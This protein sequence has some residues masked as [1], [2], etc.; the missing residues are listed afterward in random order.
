MTNTDLIILGVD[1]H[2]MSEAWFYVPRMLN[3]DTL[4]FHQIPGDEGWNTK[5]ISLEQ[6][7]SLANQSQK[8]RSAA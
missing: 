1:E 5:A 7:H 3:E 6:I 2:E 8:L 4:A